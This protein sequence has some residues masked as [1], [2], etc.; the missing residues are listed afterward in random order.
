MAKLR[1]NHSGGDNGM[2]YKVGVFG[3]I[4]AILYWGFSQLG[5]GDSPILDTVR[6]AIEQPTS[7]EEVPK[8]TA[9]EHYMPT[10][11]TGQ[12]VEHQYYTLSY[13]EKHEQPEWVAYEITRERL[14]NKVADR[15]D[16]FRPDPKVKTKSAAPSDYRRSGYTRGHLAPAGDMGFSERAMSETFYMSNMSPQ[17]RSCNMGVW[18]ELEEQARDWGRK[19]KHLYIVTGPILT[20]PKIETIG[21]NKVTVPKN[22]YKIIL[23]VTEPEYKGIGFIIPNALSDEHLTEYAVTIDEVED[24]TGIDFFPVFL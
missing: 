20:E 24:I 8:E 23:D 9:A 14:N 5:E 11:T 19:Y 18:R 15:T 13:S 4:L 12:I 22:Y 2:M 16:N 6:E 17:E 10:S 7:E 3:F 1:T 21:R